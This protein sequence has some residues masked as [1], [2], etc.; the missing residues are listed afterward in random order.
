MIVIAALPA[1]VRSDRKSTTDFAFTGNCLATEIMST[2][3]NQYLRG[4]RLV[5]GFRD[6][7]LFLF[8]IIE[9]ST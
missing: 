3:R 9:Q 2:S 4:S 8:S 6:N 1:P 5:L 7:S